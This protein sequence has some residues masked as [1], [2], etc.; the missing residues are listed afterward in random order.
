M[1]LLQE[2]LEVFSEVIQQNNRIV[3]DSHSLKDGTYRLI[4]MND[5][6]NWEVKKTIEVYYDKKTKKTI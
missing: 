1:K 6:G 3:T 2:I 4:E 5:Q